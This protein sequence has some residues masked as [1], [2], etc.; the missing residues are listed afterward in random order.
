MYIPR[1][2]ILLGTESVLAGLVGRDGAFGD[3]VG[4]VVDTVV[5]HANSVPVE[6][7]SRARHG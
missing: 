6:R 3:T 5:Q 1:S 2:A 4:A 7:C